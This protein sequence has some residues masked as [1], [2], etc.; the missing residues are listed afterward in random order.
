MM[1]TYW[2]ILVVEAIEVLVPAITWSGHGPEEIPSVDI[3]VRHFHKPL[4]Q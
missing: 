1:T 3:V 4:M 2:K